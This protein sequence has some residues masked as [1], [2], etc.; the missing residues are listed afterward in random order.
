VCRTQ[1]ER[2]PRGAREASNAGRPSEPRRGLR[3]ERLVRAEWHD[4]H[5]QPL[6]ECRLDGVEAAVGDD[7]V[8]VREQQRL[9]HVALDADIAWLR[10]E[11]GRVLVAP[12]G[13]DE[14]ERLVAQACEDCSEK[15]G[16]VVEDSAE[17]GVDGWP[18]RQ[19]WY[20]VR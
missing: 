2:L 6:A 8:T 4:D 16:T 7:K 9:W 19:G 10:A 5:R 3:V 13:E 15:A 14:C 12:N 18:R 20:P 1:A 11:V 17:S